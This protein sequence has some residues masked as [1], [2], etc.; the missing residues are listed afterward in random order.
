MDS[1][2]IEITRRCPFG[3][4]KK[5]EEKK[6]R[7]TS[8]LPPANCITENRV[9]GGAGTE[10]SAASSLIPELLLVTAKYY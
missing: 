5:E 10:G 7:L 3:S 6:K 2:K 1:V 4:K 8:A 9:P